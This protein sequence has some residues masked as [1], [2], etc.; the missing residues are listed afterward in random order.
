MDMFAHIGWFIAAVMIVG[1]GLIGRLPVIGNRFASIG[2][3]SAHSGRSHYRLVQKARI[4]SAVV[5]AVG[6]GMLGL[7]LWSAVQFGPV[8]GDG[9]PQVEIWALLT[10]AP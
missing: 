4:R 9:F 10:R 8:G 7:H 3:L 1:L 5:L 6:Y 2:H